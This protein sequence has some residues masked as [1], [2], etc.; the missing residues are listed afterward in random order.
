MLE[1]TQQKAAGSQFAQVPN[2]SGSRAAVQRQGS[3]YQ[4]RDWHGPVIGNKGQ[5]RSPETQLGSKEGWS[6]RN[7]RHYR[8]ALLRPGATSRQVSRDWGEEEVVTCCEVINR[9]D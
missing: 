8:G 4:E 6:L 1:A 3:G 9:S 2:G 7:Q 5:G